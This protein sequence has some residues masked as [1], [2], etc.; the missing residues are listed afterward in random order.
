VIC[1]SLT[2][3]LEIVFATSMDKNAPTRLRTPAM[4]TAWRGFSAFVAIDVA[5]ALAVSSPAPSAPPR[6][7]GRR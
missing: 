1:V 7:R 3:P 5:I 6:R 4:S 2:S